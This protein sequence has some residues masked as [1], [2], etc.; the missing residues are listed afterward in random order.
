MKQK[1]IRNNCFCRCGHFFDR[2]DFYNPSL[3]SYRD[4]SALTRW[5][6]R[7]DFFHYGEFSEASQVKKYFRERK[8]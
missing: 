4:C 6:N 2:H 7:S 8:E 5:D 3:S 1:S